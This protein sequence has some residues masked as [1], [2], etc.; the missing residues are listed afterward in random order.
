VIVRE[1]DWPGNDLSGKRLSGKVIVRE[2][3]V[4]RLGEEKT[5]RKNK[6]PQDENIMSA[7][8]MQGG[9]KKQ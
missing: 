8:A 7:S 9:H 4:K 2:T 6:K 5:E 3:S 1:S